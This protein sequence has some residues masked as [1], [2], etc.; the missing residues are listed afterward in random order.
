MNEADAVQLLK[1]TLVGEFLH[2]KVAELVGILDCMP[3][4]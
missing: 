3:L 4:R 2:A 1:N